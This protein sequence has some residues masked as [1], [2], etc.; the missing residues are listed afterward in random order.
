[1]K[2]FNILLVIFWMGFV[3]LGQ[4]NES[5]PNELSTF[6][7]WVDE[8]NVGSSK[9]MMLQY[10]SLSSG[11]TLQT[12]FMGKVLE[13]CQAKGC[14]MKVELTDGGETMVRFKDYGF[15]MPK[16]IAGKNV[17]VDGI[18]FVEEMSIDDQKHYAKDAGANQ[19]DLSKI[20]STKRTYAF[21]ANGALIKN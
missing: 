19:E 7:V 9:D 8:S 14:W 4:E 15:F 20:T 17:V 6:G 11:D 5:T 16:D 10:E 2:G 13:V 3:S 12:K 18:A 1:M 21:E